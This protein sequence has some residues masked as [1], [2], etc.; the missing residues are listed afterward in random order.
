M[1]NQL[2]MLLS[3]RELRVNRIRA[4]LTQALSVLAEIKQELATV[5]KELQQ[6]ALQRA[7]WEVDWQRW[8]RADGIVRH[9]QDYNLSH[10]ALS[11]WEDDATFARD[12]ILVR[13]SQATRRVREIRQRLLKAEQLLEAMRQQLRSIEH[14]DR[15]RRVA[16]TESR[17]MDEI[18]SVG[19]RVASFE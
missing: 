8:L 17:L 5:A 18:H 13:H 3:I 6:I 7:T 14:R 1:K 12:E 10:T 4:E 19:V 16:L 11:A 2:P 9:G 15:V